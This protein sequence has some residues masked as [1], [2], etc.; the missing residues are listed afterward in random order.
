MKVKD[1]Y[2]IMYI[3]FEFRKTTAIETLTSSMLEWL[4]PSGKSTSVSTSFNFFL[5]TY[6][7]PFPKPV[8]IQS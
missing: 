3:K 8:S 6:E 2:N 4:W 7:Q 1:N 5:V